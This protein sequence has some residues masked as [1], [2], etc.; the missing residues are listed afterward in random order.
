MSTALACVRACV[1]TLYV[2]T[3]EACLG[4]STSKCMSVAENECS[5]G[6]DGWL[7]TSAYAEVML[8]RASDLT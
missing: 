5:L 6:S 1:H 2:R 8:Y 3:G 7:R 4:T